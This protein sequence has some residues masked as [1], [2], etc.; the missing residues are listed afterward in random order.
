[1]AQ[2][3]PYIFLARA[4]DSGVGF[5]GLTILL[6]SAVILDGAEAGAGCCGVSKTGNSSKRTSKGCSIRA[7]SMQTASYAIARLNV[8]LYLR[9]CSKVV[10]PLGFLEPLPNLVTSKQPSV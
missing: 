1:M 7:T 3:Y 9:R 8:K 2:S 6:A 4:C 10:S 5:T